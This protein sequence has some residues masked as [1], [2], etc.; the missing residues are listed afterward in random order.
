VNTHLHP[1]EEWRGRPIFTAL[2]VIS[3]DIFELELLEI[4][5][6]HTLISTTNQQARRLPGNAFMGSSPLYAICETA[7]SVV[8]SREASSDREM[9]A[10]GAIFPNACRKSLS[11]FVI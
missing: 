10:C 1:A 8:F 2:L 7:P 6:S 3:G 5:S 9:M 11:I 4:V